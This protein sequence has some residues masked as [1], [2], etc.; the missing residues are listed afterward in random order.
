M[1]WIKQAI[2]YL[3]NSLCPIPVELNEI[4]W[5]SE[6]SSKT[7]RLAQH[8]CAFANQEGG[9]FLVYGVNDDTT[10]FSVSKEQ[11]DEIIRK[12]GNIARNNLM[13][14]LILEHAT[15]DFNGNSLLFIH[16]PENVEKPAYIRGG[17]IYDSYSRSVGQTVKMNHQE[18]KQLIAESQ[19]L[20][21]H[22]Q[23]ALSNATTDEVLRL[24][25]YNCYFRLTNRNVPESKT[26]ILEALTNE[27][28][29][30]G[31]GENWKITNLGA[32]LF[33]HDLAKFKRL[34]F[35]TLRIILYKDKNRLEA[36]PELNFKEGYACGFEHFIQFIMER[37]SVE[38]I[39]KAL[40]VTEKSYPERSVREIL[41]NALIHQNLWQN[42]M[43]VMVE[44]FSDR[45]EIT[46]PGIP[47]VDVI[48]FIDTPP[49]SRNE[50]IAILMRLFEICEQRGS[51][52]D[53][54]VKAIEDA[55]LPA[56]EF[57]KGDN[58]TKVFIYSKKTFS[59]MTKEDRIRACYQH[60]CLK[61]MEKAQMTNQSF[62]ERMGIEEENASMVSRIIKDAVNS[63]LIKGFNPDSTSKKHAKYIPFW[64]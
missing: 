56:P 40:R 23:T 43:Y 48:R 57:I 39:D 24:L 42:G 4:D 52:I 36:H 54:A 21:F 33:A 53:R 64:A 44:I 38:V 61:Y 28:F 45:M 46:N 58:Y 25:D 13:Q 31:Q 51:G 47:L 32:L 26:A 1:N 37:T 10:M 12:L 19:G 29:V 8:L 15:V 62:R 14:P 50:K 18:V 16:I 34:E 17:T 5:K 35:K 7:D 2:K 6:L 9:G 22:E 11:A 3:E 49:Q 63:G 59:Q 41:A 55:L 27:K 60:C 20:L 30:T